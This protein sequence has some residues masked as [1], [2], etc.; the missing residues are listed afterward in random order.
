MGCCCRYSKVALT[1]GYLAAGWSLGRCHGASTHADAV[2][3]VA[4][5][6]NDMLA[7]ADAELRPA[8]TEPIE[9]IGPLLPAK[10]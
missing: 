8:D 7:S 1:F 9:P 3:P 4:E 10:Q 6:A 2:S 5:C